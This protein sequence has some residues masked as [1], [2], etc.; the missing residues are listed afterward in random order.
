[1]SKEHVLYGGMKGMGTF[2]VTGRL[3]SI[4]KHRIFAGWIKG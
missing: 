3:K 1:M 2:G 4:V